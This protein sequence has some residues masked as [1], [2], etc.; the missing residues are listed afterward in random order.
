MH[1]ISV[2][3]SF[4]TAEV[5]SFVC[6][7]THRRTAERGKSSL[8]PLRYSGGGYGG[9]G[10]ERPM[11][12]SFTDVHY[13]YG[14]GR[15]GRAGAGAGGSNGSGICCTLLFGV[16]LFS[17]AFPVLWW[18]EGNAVAVY[19]SLREAKSEVVHV[20]DAVA[21]SGTKGRLVYLSGLTSGDTIADPD[22]GISVPNLVNLKR[23]SETY[24]WVEKKHERRIKEGDNTRVETTYTYDKQWRDGVVDSSRFRHPEGHRNPGG[25]EFSSRTLV[26]SEVGVGDGFVLTSPLVSQLTR[27]QSIRLLPPGESE[28]GGRSRPGGGGGYGKRRKAVAGGMNDDSANEDDDAPPRRELGGRASST[29]HAPTKKG[30]GIVD[31]DDDDDDV[32]DAGSAVALP[33][34]GERSVA[35]RSLPDGYEVSGGIAYKGNGRSSPGR[36]AVGDR[37]VRFSS[38]PAGQP[39][40]VLAQQAKNGRLKPYKAKSGKEVG[41]VKNG[42]VSAVAMITGAERANEFQTWMLRG[43][44][45]GMMM[46]GTMMITSPIG[47]VV[48]Y[49][50]YIP[51]LGGI[52]ASLINLGIFL[53][54][55]TVSIMGSLLVI[56]VSWLFHRPLLATALLATCAAVTV[57]TYALQRDR[58]RA[59][60]AKAA[61]AAAAAAA[62]GTAGGGGGVSTGRAA[63]P[64]YSTP[65][66]AAAAARATGGHLD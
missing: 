20:K 1:D 15:R 33:R 4:T 42:K 23:V 28:S 46:F 48:N 2:T 6:D 60:A 45:F 30:K 16:V 12:N 13:E 24:Q 3:P 49:L 41:M 17:M 32:E 11:Q 57:G 40:S 29:R 8:L 53:A 36:P 59:R 44:G 34:L 22:F 9:G 25:Q 27:T 66:A 56:G 14:T 37:R 58:G 51:L 62:A 19:E 10:Y 52:A 39:V 21:S 64:D 50:R 26:A 65:A 61:A 54:G 31:E 63:A 47:H 43:V 38:L 55:L 35:V 18:N 7:A 5:S